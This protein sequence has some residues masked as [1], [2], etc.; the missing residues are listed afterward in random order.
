MDKQL[1]FD[2][3]NKARAQRFVSNCYSLDFVD[4]IDAVWEKE[5]GKV[6]SYEDHGISRLLFFAKTYPDVDDI[7]DEIK[8]GVYYIEFV[9]KNIGE[10]TPRQCHIRA[11]MMR[12][13]NRDCGSLLCKAE[14]SG[15]Y[16]KKIG[17]KASV[18]DVKDIH[19]LLWGTFDT[20]ISHLPSMEEIRGHLDQYS[21]YRDG[22]GIITTLLQVDVQPRSF[23][24]NQVINNNDRSIIHAMMLN[25]LE[26][27]I[28]A[29]GKYMYSWVEDTN[30]ASMKFH[31]KYGMSAD[32]TISIVYKLE[33]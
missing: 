18:D 32:G 3:I 4:S 8:E 9:T 33:R 6:F 2:Y 30:I 19:D 26:K 10:Y 12:M 14:L 7:L 11:R 13:A 21:V 25:E 29:G 1:I 17:Y 31:E 27:Y 22:K 20:E 23:Y 5:N 24:I 16:N 15:F 28:E